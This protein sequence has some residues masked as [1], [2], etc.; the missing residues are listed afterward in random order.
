[1]IQATQLSEQKLPYPTRRLKVLGGVVEEYV[2]PAD[3]KAEVL[4]Q[5][6]IFE[7]VPALNEEYFDIH[8]GKKFQVKD[9]RVTR[10]GGHNMLVSPYYHLS[11]G[12]VIDWMPVDS[13]HKRKSRGK[14]KGKR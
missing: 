12:T 1:M 13:A 2:I 3:K 6:Y 9:F 11:G 4:N 8:E 14:R 5:L 7:P 10:E